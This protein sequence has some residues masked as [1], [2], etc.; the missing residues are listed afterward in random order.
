MYLFEL[1][2]L[3]SI[4]KHQP[5]AYSILLLNEFGFKNVPEEQKKV[6][7][8]HIDNCSGGSLWVSCECSGRHASV[9]ST[10]ERNADTPWVLWSDWLLLSTT[11]PH[12][13]KEARGRLRVPLPSAS[14][15]K[16]GYGLPSV[17]Q[18]LHQQNLHGERKPTIY[19]HIHIFLHI[20]FSSLSSYK[21]L[22]SLKCSF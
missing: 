17:V 9:R 2:P 12:C 6:N 1:H 16:S 4:H 10:G 15:H 14:C 18:Y 8:L 5:L 7:L 20:F 13:Y 11:L 3:G 22:W 19:I 21:L